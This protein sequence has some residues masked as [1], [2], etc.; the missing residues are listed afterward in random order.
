MSATDMAIAAE[1]KVRV[2]EAGGLWVVAEK[3]GYDRRNL[4]RYTKGQSAPTS[5]TL[6]TILQD[7]GVDVPAFFQDVI[8]RVGE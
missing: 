4:D 8:R 2:D 1:L 6:L 5:S 7:M 3:I